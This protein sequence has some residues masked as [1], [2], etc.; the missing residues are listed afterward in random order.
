[1]AIERNPNDHFGGTN[2]TAMTIQPF[3]PIFEVNGLDWYYCLAGS[4]Y[5]YEAKTLRSARSHF[6]SI[7]I[8][9]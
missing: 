3:S 8:H 9:L 6:L 7:I 4:D 5:L 1:M 2:K